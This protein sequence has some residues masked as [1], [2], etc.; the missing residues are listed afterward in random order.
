MHGVGEI[1]NR[2]EVAAQAKTVR[3]FATMIEE[4]HRPAVMCKPLRRRPFR[5]NHGPHGRSPFRGWR[6]A[7]RLL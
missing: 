6:W 4:K 7:V 5:Q 3:K 1:N 2:L